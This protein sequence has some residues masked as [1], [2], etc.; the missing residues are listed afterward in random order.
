MSQ[1]VIGLRVNGDQGSL[2]PPPLLSVEHLT[3]HFPVKKGVVVDREVARVRAVDDVSFTLAPRETLGVVGESGCGKSTLAKCLLRLIS[4]TGGTISY[5]GQDFSRMSRR[6]VSAVRR[7]VQMVFQDPQASLNPRK[8][9]VDILSVALRLRGV[10][11]SGVL[12][13]A[14]DLLSQVGL[15]REHVNRFPH[16]FSGGQ[17]QRIGIAR[18]VAVRPSLIVLDEPVSALDVSVQAQVINLLSDLQESFQLAY[19]YIAHNLA[20]VRHV[21]DRVAVMYLGKIVESASVDEL[22]ERPGHPYTAAL[23]SSIPVP[24]LKAKSGRRAITAGEPPNPLAPPSGCRFHPR[25]PRA[26]AVCREVEPPLTS[27]PGGH[28]VACHRPMNVGPDELATSRRSELSPL[29]SG[30]VEP[31]IE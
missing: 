18:A 10:P 28:L 17:R 7:E 13:E 22:Y 5:W 23:L 9:V 4:P 15:D 16:E 24:E 6:E 8:R 27:Y 1:G 3:V 31:V 20:V 2:P 30:N 19:L 14:S 11:R 21:S 29:T 12:G 25:C 26:A